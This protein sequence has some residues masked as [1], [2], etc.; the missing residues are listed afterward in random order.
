MWLV[1]V[2]S[3]RWVWLVG[4][5]GINGC[6]CKEVYRFSHIIYPYSSC[7]YGHQLYAFKGRGVDHKVEGVCY[8]EMNRGRICAGPAHLLQ[9]AV[10]SN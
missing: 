8:I 10:I 7:I 1:G 2:V 5:G 6:D 3:R 9:V 4:V